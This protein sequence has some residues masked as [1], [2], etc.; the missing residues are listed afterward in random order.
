METLQVQPA[1]AVAPTLPA[2]TDM[3]CMPKGGESFALTLGRALEKM[4]SSVP[5]GSS[6]A[7][8]A[9]PGSPRGK[10]N[11]GSSVDSSS[12]VGVLLTCFV[13]DILKPAPPVALSTEGAQS[14][15][16]L[17]SPESTFGPPRNFA[18]SLN[19]AVGETSANTGTF[20]IPAPMAGVAAPPAFSAW[21]G[22]GLGTTAP[23]K[24]EA[25]KSTPR[26][27]GHATIQS[28]VLVSTTGRN[29]SE[30]R[31][32]VHPVSAP[33]WLPGHQDTSSLNQPVAPQSGGALPESKQAETSNLGLAQKSGPSQDLLTTPRSTDSW[34][35]SKQLDLAPRQGTP[36]PT[37]QATGPSTP[38]SASDHPKLAETSSLLGKSNGAEVQTASNP[39][40]FAGQTGRTAAASAPEAGNSPTPIYVTDHS[41]QAKFSSLPG[42]FKGTELQT[43]SNPTLSGDHT[44]QTALT[45]G[46][47]VGDSSTRFSAPDPLEV[48]ESSILPGKFAGADLPA[49]SNST[50]STGQV[51]QDAVALGLER[52]SSS[53]VVSTTNRSKLAESPSAQGKVAS[54]EVQAASIPAP[55]GGKTEQSAPAS[56]GGASDCSV[57]L[58]ANDPP[59]LAKFSSLLG[60]SAGS[61]FQVVGDPKP[62]TGEAGQASPAL[63][64][65]GRVSSAPVSAADPPELADFS[66]LVGRLAGGQIDVKSFGNAV[67]P[68]PTQDDFATKST[69]GVASTPVGNLRITAVHSVQVPPAPSSESLVNIP[70]K[71][72][73]HSAQVPSSVATEVARQP[74]SMSEAASAPS[75]L[76]SSASP[77]PSPPVEANSQPAAPATTTQKDAP[78]E[79]NSVRPSSPIF[80]D[81]GGSAPHANLP[82]ASTSGQGKS[83]QQSGSAVG[84]N[85]ADIRTFAPSPAN[86]PAPDPTGNLLTAHAPSVPASHASASAPQ[87]APS[88]SQPTTTLSAWQN[89]DGGAGKIVRS[90]SLSDS[91]T[92]VEMHVEL[93]TGALGPLDVHAVVHEGA[94]GAEI[95]VQGQEAHT[96]LAA[97]LP[98]LERALGERNLRVDSINVYHDH[99]GGGMSGGEKQDSQ[100]GS[101][102]SPQRQ[103]SPWDNPPQARNTASGSAEDEELINPAPG[104]SV[105]A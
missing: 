30:D 67:Q 75:P 81:A 22:K 15:D 23:R 10:G 100:S 87:T 98:S 93:R 57:P 101:S 90:A 11:L 25:P 69:P 45:S 63:D 82:N 64:P 84:D 28:S 31:A 78:P 20:S 27:R 24:S 29:Q 47:E 72:T 79:A 83:G 56:T 58:S 76:T 51:G 7:P 61:N 92:G 42:K 37:P 65:E 96:L 97:G 36:V 26:E 52:R 32:T 86:N 60:K 94:V 14:A 33:A 19:T 91:A 1:G 89:Y 74:G 103:V 38:F 62:S 12:T 44:G 34:P 105:Q 4:P 9:S 2:S 17:P 73:L 104:L 49:D 13:A 16:N 70:A 77:V 46:Q 85:Q 99:V 55:S 88:P 6:I 54:A 21:A 43:A 39:T 53:T 68:A 5:N 95:H 71:V 48:P 102:P 40:L 3:S 35:L 18:S 59:A 66:T 8:K 50:P 41:A 80:A